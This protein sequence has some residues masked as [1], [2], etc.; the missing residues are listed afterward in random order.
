MPAPPPL[1]YDTGLM[2]PQRTLIRAAIASRLAPLLKANG[3][4]LARIAAMPRP[5]RSRD[6]DEIGLLVNQLSGVTPAVLIAL[7]RLPLQSTNTDGREWSGELE[8]VLYAVSSSA[9]SFVDG[10]LASDGVAAADPTA[11]PGIEAM[12]E[13]IRQ[14]LLGQDLGVNTTS[15]FRG[16][17]EDELYTFS[18]IT[19]WEQHYTMQLEIEINPN[20]AITEIATEVLVDN[21]LDGADP[22]NPLVETITQLEAP[23]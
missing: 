18:D 8:I 2:A 3:G 20:R 9:R 21:D 13:Q 5:L 19:I 4:F 10:R 23:P 7:G 15:E 14:L 16:H 6:E 17:A 12:L 11:D 22:V 1:V